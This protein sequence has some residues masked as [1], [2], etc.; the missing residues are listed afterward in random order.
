MPP[1]RWI[2]TKG[3]LVIAE[4]IG[5]AL[6]ETSPFIS[7]SISDQPLPEGTSGTSYSYTAT[8]SGGT[9]TYYWAIESGALP[10]GLSLDSFTGT[11]SGTPK[12]H[13]TF[14]FTISV[15][16]CDETTPSITRAVTLI[17]RE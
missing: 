14:N 5:Y 11:I 8:V 7:L 12:Q 1:G 6:R 13:G 9:P 17:I 4:A 16:D 2:I 3:H 10:A 15:S